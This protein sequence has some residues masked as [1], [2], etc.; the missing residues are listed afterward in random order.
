MHLGRLEHLP[1]PLIS[2][3]AITGISIFSPA[4]LFLNGQLTIFNMAAPGLVGAWK[5]YAPLQTPQAFINPAEAA[6]GGFAGGGIDETWLS[7]AYLRDGEGYAGTGLS[8]AI[9]PDVHGEI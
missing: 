2:T 4:L 1:F 7:A 9:I 8:W 6:D 5:N 3:V